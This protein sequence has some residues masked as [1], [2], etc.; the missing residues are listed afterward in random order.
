MKFKKNDLVKFRGDLGKVLESKT[1]IMPSEMNN[2]NL[3]SVEFEESRKEW[4]NEMYLVKVN[5]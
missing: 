3:Y 5:L 4:V 2:Y 1:I